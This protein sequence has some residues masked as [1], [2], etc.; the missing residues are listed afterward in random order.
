MM[1]EGVQGLIERVILDLR[2]KDYYLSTIILEIII[3]LYTVS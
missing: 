3:K 2:L 1:R